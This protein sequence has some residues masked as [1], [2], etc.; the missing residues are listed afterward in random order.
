[1]KRELFYLIL[2]P[3]HTL[4]G[5]ASSS[6]VGWATM[7]QARRLW[8]WFSMRSLDFSIDL[9][10][11]AT[12]LPWG[13]FMEVK[14]GWCIRL[15]NSQP[16]VSQL[17]WKY[18]RLNV[19]QPNG[20]PWP[21]TGIALP[22]YRYSSRLQQCLFHAFWFPYSCTGRQKYDSHCF[23]TPATSALF[24]FHRAVSINTH[25]FPKKL[26]QSVC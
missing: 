23:M 17:S 24:R 11:P 4:L 15:T 8:V 5:G 14:G 12:L 26:E 7:L 1:M 16:S 2:N 6:V 10:L 25:L 9:I 19:S 22:L 20:P 21:L 18:G 3:Y 13:I